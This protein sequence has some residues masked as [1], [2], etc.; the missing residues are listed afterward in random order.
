MPAVDRAQTITGVTPSATKAYL[1]NVAETIQNVL[2]PAVKGNAKAES[3]AI[4]CLGTV[5]RIA[6]Q[7]GAAEG[8]HL[9]ALENLARSPLSA[10]PAAALTEAAALDAAEAEAAQLLDSIVNAPTAPGRNFEQ[11]RLEN[12]L[13]AHPRGGAKLRVTSAIQLQGGR[14]KQ[15]ILLSQEGAIDLPKDLVVR[16]DWVSAVTGTSVFSEFEV[17]KRLWK[18]GMKVPQPLILETSSDALGSPFMVVTRIGGKLEGD[19]FAPPLR[20]PLALQLAEQ[21]GKL[22]ALDASDFVGLPGIVEHSYTHEQLR[23]EIAEFRGVIEKLG[24]PSQTVNVALKWLEANVSRVET[25]R[26]VVHGD[27]AFHNLLCDGNELTAVL[28]WELVHVGSPGRDLGYLRSGV[29]MMTTWPR[30]MEAYRKA[31]GANLSEF[32]VDFYTLFSSVWLYQL[33]MKANAGICGG[34]IHD[35]EVT[36]VCSHSTPRLLA[37][38]SRELRAILAKG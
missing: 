21:V 23:A 28:D 15:T 13:R 8:A 30:F 32:A 35:M 2:L 24:V 11:S 20:E 4:D 3:R 29:E 16:Q 7:F 1:V 37:R 14:S 18:A 10:D 19:M 31:G 12:Y 34:M 36:Y 5:T 22:H 17:L 33:L 26:T 6:S 9:Q 25:P 38:M 27:I